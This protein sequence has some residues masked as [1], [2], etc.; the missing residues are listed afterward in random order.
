MFLRIQ[1]SRELGYKPVGFRF[2]F[3]GA[4][5]HQFND[6][7]QL[8]HHCVPGLFAVPQVLQTTAVDVWLCDAGLKPQNG[9]GN[10]A[11][12][13]PHL[14]QKGMIRCQGEQINIL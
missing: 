7:L 10:C 14:S 1:P 2:R 4:L 3:G 6:F 13:F 12:Y 9:H 11:E 8:T 5:I